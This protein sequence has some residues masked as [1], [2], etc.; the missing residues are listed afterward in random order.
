MIF[1]CVLVLRY[2]DDIGD[3]MVDFVI[4]RDKV[5]FIL[6]SSSATFLFLEEKVTKEIQDG[7]DNSPFL[8]LFLD[9]AIVVLWLQHLF[10]ML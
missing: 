5:R 1:Q 6:H 9:F 2:P 3:G 7:N 10:C 8:S 4:A